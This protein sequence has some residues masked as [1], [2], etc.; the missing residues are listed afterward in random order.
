MEYIQGVTIA[1]YIH[2]NP[3]KIGDIFFQIIEGFRYLEENNI[4]HRDIRPENFIISNDRIAK[5]IDF[6]FGKIIDFTNNNK[7]ISLNWRYTLP[8]EFKDEIYDIK[9]EIYFIGKMFEEIISDIGN[10][11][12]KYFEVLSK[13]ILLNPEQRIQSFLDIYRENIDLT[14]N[15][16]VFSFTDKKAYQNFANNLIP[17]YSERSNQSEYNNQL[18]SILRDLDKLYKDSI[19]EE[20]LQNNDKLTRIFIK[21]SYKYF[22]SQKF[23][24]EHLLAF[25][26]LLKSSSENKKK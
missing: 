13:M 3:D 21:G 8:N 2:E 18:D 4:L 7:S 25:I 16:F 12:F 15:E 17:I 5:I 19:L 9:T 26:D 20:V 6:G 23:K 11:E 22:R 14:S 24:V 10:I 1:Q